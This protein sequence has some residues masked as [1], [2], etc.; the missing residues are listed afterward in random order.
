LSTDPE[1]LFDGPTDASR[2]VVLAH[3]AG[4]GM[5]SPFMDFFAKGLAKRGIRAAR[6]EFP[7]L[8]SRR[9]TGKQK[10]PDRGPALRETWL[11]VMNMLG[12]E[13][14][15]IGGES[16]GGGIASLVFD[17]RPGEG[18]IQTPAA[19]MIANQISQPPIGSSCPAAGTRLGSPPYL[20]PPPPGGRESNRGQPG[21]LVFRAGG[22]PPLPT[23]AMALRISVSDCTFRRL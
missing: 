18:R 5:D 7:H 12:R 11:K 14:P 17:Y 16:M 4:G 13:G 10:P 2:T 3:G 22:P 21:E 23:L 8:A 15:V 1:F 20:K 19:T 9:V 6:F